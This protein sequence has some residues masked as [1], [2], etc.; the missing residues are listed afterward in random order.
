MYEGVRWLAF[1]RI[2][3]DTTW[4]YTDERYI[5]PFQEAIHVEDKFYAASTRGKPLSFDIT[6]EF[7]SDVKLVA[8]SIRTRHLG[9]KKNYIVHSIEKELLMVQRY[10]SFKYE[11]YSRRTTNVVVFKLYSGKCKWTKINNSGDV[12]LFYGW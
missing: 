1:I 7:Q 12:S 11:P 10:M 3:K 9:V 5:E 4:T 6:P 2:S 8:R